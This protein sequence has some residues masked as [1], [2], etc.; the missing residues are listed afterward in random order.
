MANSITTQILNDGPR[1]TVI[2]INIFLD[3]SDLALT[4]VA[5]PALLVQTNPVTTQLRIDKMRCSIEDSQAPELE[6]DIVW[7][8]ATPV[9][10]WQLMGRSDEL[11]FQ[12]AGGLNNN[13]GAG[14]TGKIQVRTQGWSAGAILS[15]SILLYLVKQ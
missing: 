15:A 8:A 11:N 5:D 13:A 9:V 14:K 12:N 4:T 3:T 7:D 2:R 1:N 10:A 6:V